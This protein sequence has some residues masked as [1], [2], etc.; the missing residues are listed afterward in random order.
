MSHTI[1]IIDTKELS[2]E[3][4]AYLFRCCGDPTTDS[5]HTISVLHEPTKEDPR[6]HD[7]VL[8][9]MKTKHAAKH[10]AKVAWR[11]KMKKKGIIG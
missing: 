9:E 6:T 2:D 10:E 1:E 4:V 11:K 7:E 5:W 3:H 8:E